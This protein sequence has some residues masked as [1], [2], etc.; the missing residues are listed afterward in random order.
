MDLNYDKEPDLRPGL[1]GPDK[2]PSAAE[3]TRI[4]R[5][6]LEFR[7]RYNLF[8]AEDCAEHYRRL[9]L[10]CSFLGILFGF[11][12][13]TNML[14]FIGP[15]AY[16]AIGFISAMLGLLSV[17][18]EFAPKAYRFASALKSYETLLGK[19]RYEDD[20]GKIVELE[21]VYDSIELDVHINDI[22]CAD[23][24]N[25]TVRQMG[26]DES[27]NFRIGSFKYHTRFLFD[28]RVERM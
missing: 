27:G 17:V 13:M 7:V 3:E 12:A 22:T 10:A 8:L 1:Q 4:R 23:A 21:R 15:V 9:S 20:M 18:Y 16:G 24:Y 5:H 6:N 11:T 2:D 25:R 19:V 26:L 14:D 28:W